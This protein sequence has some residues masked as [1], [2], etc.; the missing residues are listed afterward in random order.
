MPTDQVTVV[1]PTFNERENLAHLI[2]AVIHQGYRLLVVDDSSPDG[3]G[4]LADRLAS[5]EPGVSVL[6]RRR[7]EGL[8][9]AY[10]DGF[11]RAIADGA[12]IVVEMD[13]DFSHD[14]LD[15]PRLVSAVEAGADLAIGSRYVEGGATPD[16]PLLRRLIS[17]AGNL[18]ARVLLGVPV[19]DMTAGFRAFRVASLR[20]LRYRETEAT[21]YG[22]QVEMAWRAHRAGMRIIEVPVSF[23]DRT[24]GESKMGTDVVLEAMRLVTV[25]G[26]RRLR[27]SVR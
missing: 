6:H 10:A 20:S 9:R 24:R 2:S 1:V 21:G 13:A 8:G 23:R 3:T 18:Y 27:G 12:E 5:A 25:W 26:L 11:D 14:P 15:L 7:K 19:R 22:F 16:W 17:R 4:D